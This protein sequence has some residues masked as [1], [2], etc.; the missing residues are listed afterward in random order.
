MGLAG[1]APDL[2]YARECRRVGG[3][4]TT[5]TLQLQPERPAESPAFERRATGGV[6]V[7]QAS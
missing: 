6:R 3:C 7:K 1:R 4:S 2:L 5:I